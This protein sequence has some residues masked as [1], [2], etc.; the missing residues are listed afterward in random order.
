MLLPNRQP[1]GEGNPLAA[2]LPF[3]AIRLGL[4]VREWSERAI[5]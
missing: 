5:G 4:P 1:N 2:H 3:I